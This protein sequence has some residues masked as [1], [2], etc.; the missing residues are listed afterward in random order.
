MKKWA[1]RQRDAR[2]KPQARRSIRYKGRIPQG[3]RGRVALP[4][5]LPS[6]PALRAFGQK[7]VFLHPGILY[8][9]LPCSILSIPFN[10]WNSK[11]TTNHYSASWWNET[12]CQFNDLYHI[13]HI[14]RGE[15]SNKIEFYLLICSKSSINGIREGNKNVEFKSEVFVHKRKRGGI[16]ALGLTF[17][18]VN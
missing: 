3:A 16:D 5:R 17:T 9:S 13:L 6:Q 1:R 18:N 4:P 12:I 11:D 8:P 15:N 10:Y 14:F 2:K 7:N